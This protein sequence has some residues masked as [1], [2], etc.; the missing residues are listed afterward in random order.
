MPARFLWKRKNKVYRVS[1]RIRMKMER[2]FGRKNE[3]LMV[4][5]VRIVCFN[6]NG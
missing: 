4:L 3:M 6:W 2:S 1:W 5:A